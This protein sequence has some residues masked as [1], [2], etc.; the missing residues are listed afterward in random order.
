MNLNDEEKDCLLKCIYTREQII[1]KEA[2]MFKELKEKAPDML[3]M[4][5]TCDYLIESH[6][7]EYECLK[8]LKRKLI[9]DCDETDV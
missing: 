9:H 4:V 1:R 3:E 5:K 6:Q 7:K 2:K 8:N